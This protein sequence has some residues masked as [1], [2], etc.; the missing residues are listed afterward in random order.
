MNFYTDGA[1]EGHN[2]ELGTVEY[3][4][5]GIYCPDLKLRFSDRIE[6]I[7]NNEAEFIALINHTD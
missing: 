4:G 3:C 6:A 7:S 5:I 1:T 2:G